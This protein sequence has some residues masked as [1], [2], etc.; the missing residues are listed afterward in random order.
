MFNVK[1]IG[2]LY[3]NYV[4]NDPERPFYSLNITQKKKDGEEYFYVNIFFNEDVEVPEN[5]T[6]I[7]VK[8]EGRLFRDKNT[9]VTRISISNA[10]IIEEIQENNFLLDES[11]TPITESITSST[12]L[13]EG[14]TTDDFAF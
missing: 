8:G 14:K 9:K 2:V 5:G 7:K 4:N 12:D 11:D 1:V 10:E 3:V 13:F 6:K